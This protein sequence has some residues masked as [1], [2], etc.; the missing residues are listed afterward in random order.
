MLN[1]DYL[2]ICVKSWQEVVCR[3]D[4]ERVMFIFFL[5]LFC[6]LLLLYYCRDMFEFILAHEVLL[7]SRARKAIINDSITITAI[8]YTP[9]SGTLA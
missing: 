7:F 5:H 3:N 6:T 1:N 9:S 4:D 8:S 2:A